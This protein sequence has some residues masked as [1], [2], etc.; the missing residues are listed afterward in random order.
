[1]KIVHMPEEG[2]DTHR[3]ANSLKY[4]NTHAITYTGCA[5]LVPGCIVSGGIQNE[6]E[7]WLVC[8][9]EHPRMVLNCSR[10]GV[11]PLPEGHTGPW[12]QEKG[13]E[14]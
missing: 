3:I 11:M 2:D 10:A 6:S 4:K 9:V 1:V 8:W 13:W 12:P 7:I 14:L 5:E